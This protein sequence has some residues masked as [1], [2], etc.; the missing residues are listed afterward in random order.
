MIGP[1]RFQQ[2]TCYCDSTADSMAETGASTGS[3][4]HMARHY[5]AAQVSETPFTLAKPQPSWVILT[6]LLSS[7]SV[8]LSCSV[9]SCH[10]VLSSCPAILLLPCSLAPLA[11][12]SASSAEAPRVGMP[13]QPTLLCS[14]PA[15]TPSIWD[16]TR[17]ERPCV[18][19]VGRKHSW[20]SHQLP[21][22]V[23]RLHG[24]ISCQSWSAG[25]QRVISSQPQSH[26]LQPRS[27]GYRESSAP[28]AVSRAT[29]SHQLP[30]AVSRATESP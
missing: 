2:C 10:T 29:E 23:S 9:L 14:T 30:A 27:A 11:A 4:T 28:A 3:E 12:L 25:L 6:V 22:A 15:F 20:Y 7:P 26:Q 13:P 24:V 17:S 1:G 19:S 16:R 5:N 18:A 8:L 21:A